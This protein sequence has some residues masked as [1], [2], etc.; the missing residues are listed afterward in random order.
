MI[1]I[2]ASL[3]VA[4]AGSLVLYR[5]AGFLERTPQVPEGHARS[6]M[7]GPPV[8]VHPHDGGKILPV[9]EFVGPVDRERL[10]EL[11]AK[12]GVDPAS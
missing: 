2:G 3:N 5:L 10:A 8:R 12:R 9:I 1:G 4:V 6:S 11:L 7:S